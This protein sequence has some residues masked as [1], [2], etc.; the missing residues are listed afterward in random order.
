M[1][2]H[3]QVAAFLERAKASGAK[4]RSEM[5]VAETREFMRGMRELGGE[6]PELARVEDRQIAGVPVRIYADSVDGPLPVL[7]F[8]HGGRFFSGDLETHDTL[9]RTLAAQSGCLL[10][11]IDYRLAP[12]HRFPAAVEDLSLVLDW[13][14]ANATE[15]GGDPSRLGVGGD[16]AGGN[17]AAVLALASPAKLS[18]LMLIYPMT[19]ATC[20]SGSYDSFATGYGPGAEDMKRGWDLY[21]PEGVNPRDPRISPLWA[22]DVSGL[23]PTYVLTAEYDTLRDEGE[24]FARLLEEADVTVT[25]ARYPGAIHGFL[26]FGG[27]LEL[28]RRAESETAAWLRN[29]L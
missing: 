9:C 24:Q 1:P 2:L 10:V 20:S 21:L 7:A 29:N 14:G 19:D 5:T 28:G 16:S 3:E 18:C 8:A 22:K 27:V 11:A 13:L 26:Q 25:A 17:L 12:E 15:I 6:P 4:P 23:P